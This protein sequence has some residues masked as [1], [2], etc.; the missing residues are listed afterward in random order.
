MKYSPGNGSG[1]IQVLIR[2]QPAW[3]LAWLI[4]CRQAFNSRLQIMARCKNT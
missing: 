2:C 4:S 3:W 1:L